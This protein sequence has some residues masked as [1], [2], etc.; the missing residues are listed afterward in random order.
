MKAPFSNIAFIS[1]KRE[2]EEWAR[3]LQKKL[4]HYKLPIEVRRQN[5]ELEFLN[6]PRH[7]FKDTTDLSGGVLAKAI[8]EG[9]DSSKFLVVIC[10]PRAAKSE[11]VCKEVQDFID[12]GREEYI[13]PF[14]ID[15]EPYAKDPENEC[16]PQ[17]LKALA[18]EREL[19]GININ[20]NGR[21][22][23]AVKVVSRVFD[24]KFDALWGRFQ[25][26]EKRKR[27]RIFL[28]GVVVAAIITIVSG[29]IWKQNLVLKEKDKGLV[30]NHSRAVADKAMQ[31]VENGDIIRGIAL[32]MEVLPENLDETDDRLI[33]PEAIAVLR[34]AY[35]NWSS[36][37]N[38]FANLVGHEGEVVYGDI[39]RDGTLI[40]TTSNDKT[41]RLWNTRDYME[42]E[43]KRME[44]SNSVFGAAFD[45]KDGSLYTTDG[46]LTRWRFYNDTI[47]DSLHIDAVHSYLNGLS[48]T[49]KGNYLNMG[50][51]YLSMSNNEV[52]D[53]NND[54][55]FSVIS[56]DETMRATIKDS[57]LLISRVGDNEMVS[58]IKIMY[59][60]S[61][62][63]CK[64][65]KFSP[66]NKYILMLVGVNDDEEDIDYSNNEIYIWNIEKG[67]QVLKY[68]EY[69]INDAVFSA[70][71]KYVVA[72]T[73]ATPIVNAKL[74]F[75]DISAK[76]EN[77]QMQQNMLSEARTIK[78]SNDGNLFL[79]CC[80]DGVARLFHNFWKQQIDPCTPYY[81]GMSINEWNRI[82]Q[83]LRTWA[84]NKYT[85]K[86]DYLLNDTLFYYDKNNKIHR[87]YIPPIDKTFQSFD[88]NRLIQ[89]LDPYVILPEIPHSFYL[90]LEQNLVV[91]NYAEVN[92]VY[93]LDN[94]HIIKSV[95]LDYNPLF[96]DIDSD[97][98][99]YSFL[100]DLPI[101]TKYGQMITVSYKNKRISFWDVN[102]KKEFIDR[103]I[104]AREEV[105]SVTCTPDGDF[106]I[107][108]DYDYIYILDYD[109][110][111]LLE[112]IKTKGVK[113]YM[114]V[115]PDKK[116]MIFIKSGGQCY[117]LPF[118]SNKSIYKWAKHIIG[119]FHL[120]DIERKQYYI[121]E[122]TI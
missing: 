80:D 51:A 26:E 55:Y 65:V 41:V 5:P 16:F 111:V 14:I 67:E 37:T 21:E 85:S 3:W 15:G 97:K 90:N 54:F 19:L 76:K 96:V 39:N 103:R 42:I 8:K 34:T 99:N 104:S 92:Y 7:V 106:L 29:F 89:G 86:I 17:A 30:I 53:S 83:N 109:S 110:Q 87:V 46:V 119:G 72:S 57:S 78:F 93:Y 122:S 35:R 6:H 114:F 63:A 91:V 47:K 102:T 95:A 73:G 69:L 13:I 70:D 49:R 112:K 40:A 61:L 84:F 59:T 68:R 31:L 117:S 52:N 115:L 94:D 105:Q 75:F 71:S 66:N 107:Y 12:S 74:H 27:K 45:P 62:G 2:D 22:S 32:I 9:L 20:E 28:L 88:P 10:S 82:K 64:A 33:V 48:F 24:L 4:E 98:F 81:G 101:N 1:Y 79:A 18:G 77:K 38:S 23:A 43:N 116:D 44:H 121:N 108:S 113:N 25:R 100:Y 56:D 60:S 36:S 50:I 120:S 118:K 58:E 11:W